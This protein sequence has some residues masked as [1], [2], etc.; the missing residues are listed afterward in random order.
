M[1]KNS[2]AI[3]GGSFGDEGKGRVVDELCSKLIAKHKKLVVY[4]WN[5]GSNAGHTVVVNGGKIILHQIPSGVLI[6]DALAILGKGMVLH[7]GDLIDEIQAIKNAAGGSLPA[8]LLIDEMAVLTMDTH[9]AFESTLRDWVKGGAGSTG[10][11]IA[12]AYSD[13]LL[14]HP[15][16]VGD[17]V[18]ADWRKKLSKHY[19]L[20]RALTHGLGANLAKRKVPNL[21]NKLSPV[22]SKNTFLD[23]FEVQR[24]VLK[25]F[26]RPVSELMKKLWQSNT[27]F[28]FEGAQGV[29]LD[30]RWGVYPDVT[31]SDPTFTGI[32]HS[33]EGLVRPE[34]IEVKAAVYKATYMSSVG[35]RRLPSIMNAKLANLIRK[36]ANEYGATTGRPRDIYH[37]DLPALRYF[38][39]VTNPTHMVLTHLDI[40]YEKY[41]IKVC[42]KYV[43]FNKKYVGYRPDQVYINGL[44]PKYKSINAWDGKLVRGISNYTSLPKK[45]SSYIE[46]F[47]EKLNLIPWILTTG[48]ERNNVITLKP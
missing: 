35:K 31:S 3:Q 21:S 24:R 36:D 42:T 48:P 29:G 1:R 28:V 10:R 11:G 6:K 16:R 17:L 30:P 7:P 13:V 15:V 9:R 14:R 18:S 33:T 22:G 32:I 43:N 40:S 8:D 41:P 5:G 12:P 25:K 38:R 26:A 39:Q 46:Y 27:P 2:Y 34:E 4:R 20:Y 45:A 37:V 23:N 44:K 47:S 19:N